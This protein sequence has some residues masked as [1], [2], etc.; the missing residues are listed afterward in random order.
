[1]TASVRTAAAQTEGLAELRLLLELPALRRLA[2]RGLSD[3]ELALVGQ[4]ADATA[5]AARAGEVLAY[6]QADMVF[7]LCL[8]ELTGDPVLSEIA[9]PLVSG[10]QV[11]RRAGVSADLMVR[12]ARE[13]GELVGLLADGVVSAV[14]RL[15][16]LHFG[17]VT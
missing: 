17:P 5:R 6:L 3:R 9:R 11:A 4:L 10:G 8:L 12:E 16:R 13:H 7:H 1:M 15:L 2:A 14:D